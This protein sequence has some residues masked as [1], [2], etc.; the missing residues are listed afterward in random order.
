MMI[1]SIYGFIQP[2]RT[3]S[4][5]GVYFYLEFH[6]HFFKKIGKNDASI[7]HDSKQMEFQMNGRNIIEVQIGA[8]PE[9]FDVRV[10]DDQNHLLDSVMFN[11]TL[12]LWA[13]EYLYVNL[14]IYFL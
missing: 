11:R 10:Y 13:A 6:F 14:L 4:M 5:Y 1:R 7:K 3:L 9:H 12:P 2:R 8:L